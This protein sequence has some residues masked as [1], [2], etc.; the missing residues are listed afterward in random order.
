M[1]AVGQR[2]VDG[3]ELGRRQQRFIGGE[4]LV[5]L[6]R[7]GDFGGALAVAVGERHDPA[8]VDA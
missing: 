5:D 4:D 3:I 1:H 6:Q 8:F 2:N 7:R